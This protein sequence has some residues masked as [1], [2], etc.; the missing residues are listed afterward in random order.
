MSQDTL[1]F[2]KSQICYL[3]RN[4]NAVKMF[5][6]VKYKYCYRL[7]RI[8]DDEIGNTLVFLQKGMY[9]TRIKYFFELFS[10]VYIKIIVNLALRELG[11]AGPA[12]L[13]AELFDPFGAP[14]TR[15]NLWEFIEQFK[16]SYSFYIEVVT[17]GAQIADVETEVIPIV[18]VSCDVCNKNISFLERGIF[19]ATAELCSNI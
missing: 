16:H 6:R 15:E 10:I 11:I 1:M 12:A 18:Y 4:K 17:D 8:N 7:V 9:Y 19:F 3:C 13:A 2:C 14:I 5:I